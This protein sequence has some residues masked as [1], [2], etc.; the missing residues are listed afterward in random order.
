M[1][2]KSPKFKVS[3]H[4]QKTDGSAFLALVP[5]TYPLSWDGST[6]SLPWQVTHGSGIANFFGS[7]AHSG[8]TF[9]A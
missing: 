8:F 4:S 3:Y 7:P 2:F 5:T 9:T 1:L 6:P